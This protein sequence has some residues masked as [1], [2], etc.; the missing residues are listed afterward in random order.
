MGAPLQKLERKTMRIYYLTTQV[1]HTLADPSDPM[2]QM[3]LR[4]PDSDM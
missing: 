2:I 4:C 3:S 1:T